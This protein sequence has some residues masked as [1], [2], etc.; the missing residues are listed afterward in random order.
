MGVKKTQEKRRRVYSRGGK[1]KESM[2]KRL[3][4]QKG[5]I[6]FAE[7]VGR[8]Q[9]N[10]EN[11][12]CGGDVEKGK[13]KGQKRVKYPKRQEWGSGFMEELRREQRYLGKSRKRVQG[14]TGKG[15]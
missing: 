14:G 12:M 13:M 6:R 3:K 11:K 15:K 4:R 2:K 1:R 9:K 8:E 7:E 10:L 5:G